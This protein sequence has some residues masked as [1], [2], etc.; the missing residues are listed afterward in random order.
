MTELEALCQSHG[1]ALFEDAA[2]AQGADYHGQPAGGLARAGAFSFYPSKN[3]GALGDAG[4]LCTDDHELAER[5]R[6]LRDLGRSAGGQHEFAGYNERLDGL[7]AALLRVKLGHVQSWNA[8]RRQKAERYRQQLAGLAGSPIDVELLDERPES[9]CIY[10]L[11]PIRLSDR[12][13]VTSRLSDRG[14]GTG[15]HY[16]V[17]VPDH[18]ALGHLP[19]VDVPVAR[20]WAARELSLPMFPELRD[21]EV[22]AVA[23]V[24]GTSVE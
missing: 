22:D 9:P 17:A 3:L 5:V 12:D 15:I 8:S 6:A 13:A 11:F 24:L 7:Q 16:P 21:D 18:P 19:P 1:L 20:D 4:A 23:E 2:Q 14:I 10:H